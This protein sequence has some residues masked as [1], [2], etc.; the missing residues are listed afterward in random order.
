[1][2]SHNG[3]TCSPAA[4]YRNTVTQWSASKTYRVVSHDWWSDNTG[5][6]HSISSPNRTRTKISTCCCALLLYCCIPAQYDFIV[7]LIQT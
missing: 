6:E 1:M 5:K 4:I 2:K 7:P 3:S